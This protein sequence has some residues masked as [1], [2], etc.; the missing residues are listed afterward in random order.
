MKAQPMSRTPNNQTKGQSLEEVPPEPQCKSVQSVYQALS[1]Q[2][3]IEEKLNFSG[4]LSNKS[5]EGE[6]KSKEIHRFN[7]NLSSEKLHHTD[8]PADGLQNDDSDDD[9]ED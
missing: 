8:H 1:Q 2:L 5:G 9:D 7:V 6:S 4:Y 3:Q